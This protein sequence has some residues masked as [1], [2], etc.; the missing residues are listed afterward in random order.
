[1]DGRTDSYIPS[2]LGSLSENVSGGKNDEFIIGSRL[3]C[4]KAVGI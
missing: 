4:P 2:P 1:M 3:L